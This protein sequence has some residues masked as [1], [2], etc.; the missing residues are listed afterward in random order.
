MDTLGQVWTITGQPMVRYGWNM[1]SISIDN[2][3]ITGQGMEKTGQ[4]MENC[5]FPEGGVNEK[6]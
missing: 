2:G 4:R 5:G 6:S 1:G 3:R